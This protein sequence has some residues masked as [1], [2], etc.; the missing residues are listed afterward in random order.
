MN[1]RYFLKYTAVG[2]PILFISPQT[3]S[4]SMVQKKKILILIELKGG[5]DGL[6]TIVPYTQSAYYSLRPSLAISKDELIKTAQT[7]R[8]GL[9]FHPSLKNLSKLVSN[10]EAAILQGLGYPE[11]SLSHFR[12]MDIWH[13]AEP[14]E[15]NLLSK[16][17]LETLFRGRIRRRARLSSV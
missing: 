13:T 2:L 17:W 4:S 10:N 9:G 6:N 8:R 5:N 15:Q 7:T 3:F 12:S 14:T 1:R 11:P 16:G